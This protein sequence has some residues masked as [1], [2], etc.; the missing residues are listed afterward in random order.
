MMLEANLLN[1]IESL[2]IYNGRKNPCLC[3]YISTIYA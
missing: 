1:P 2:I 3:S